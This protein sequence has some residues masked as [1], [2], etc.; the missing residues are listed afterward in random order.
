MWELCLS[1]YVVV[2]C[3]KLGENLI[4]A[5]LAITTTTTT[6]ANDAHP[7]RATTIIIFLTHKCLHATYMAPPSCSPAPHLPLL[8]FAYCFSRVSVCVSVNVFVYFCFASWLLSH[9]VWAELGSVSPVESSFSSESVPLSALDF[10]YKKFCSFFSPLRCNSYAECA[11][12]TVFC[13]H[14]HT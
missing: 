5:R 3:N 6:T 8:L 11:I 13:A 4:P 10:I 12:V 7:V 2:V 1:I 14:T 9:S